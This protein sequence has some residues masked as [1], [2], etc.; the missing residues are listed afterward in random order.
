E[1]AERFREGV[2]VVLLDY[3]LPDANGSDV[4]RELREI[5]PEPPII[6]VTAHASI[7]CAVDSMKGGAYYY[8][9]KMIG[10]RGILLIVEKALETTRLARE[11]RALHERERVAY[12][13]ENLIGMSEPIR[14]VKRLI[15]R[16]AERATTVL[17]SGESGTGKDL[18]A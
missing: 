5:N 9:P 11:V 8:A 10:L 6:F 18:V 4:V 17:L 13:V 16:I 1:A 7:E 12:G 2:D 15:H 3:Y 14:A